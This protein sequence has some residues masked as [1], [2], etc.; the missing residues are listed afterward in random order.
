VARHEGGPW[1]RNA[2]SRPLNGRVGD[3]PF[4]TYTCTKP[5]IVVV[6]TEASLIALIAIKE[7]SAARQHHLFF[8]ATLAD[9]PAGLSGQESVFLSLQTVSQY[10]LEY[11]IFLA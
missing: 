8:A 6:R 4:I 5:G 10:A 1:F 11:M 3:T 7:S 2:S 9:G